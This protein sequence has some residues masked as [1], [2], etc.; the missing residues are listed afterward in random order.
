MGGLPRRAT[1]I[2]QE[3]DQ[4]LGVLILDSGNFVADK[5]LAE[6]SL[7]HAGLKAELILRA[8]DR[9]GYHAMAVGEMDLYLGLKRL[10]DLSSMTGVSLLSANLV[11]S[12]GKALFK[13]HIVLKAGGTTVG[14]IGLT[15]TPANRRMFSQRVPGVTVTDPN[16]AAKE[17]I[18]DIREECDLV[19]VLS[20]IGYLRDLELVKAVPGIDILISG[21]TKRFMRRP[22]IESG[23]L[24]TS[25][26][27]E[28][29]AVGKL[30]M[31][32]DGEIKGWISRQEL[33]LMDKQIKAAVKKVGTPAGKLRHDTLVEKR[34]E[35]RQWTKY[36]PDLINLDPSFADDPQVA[37]M[38][39][40]YRK[41]LAENSVNSPGPEAGI[42]EQERY[43]G[44]EVCAGC[45]DS[46]YRFWQTTDHFRAF[47]SLSPKSAVGDPD[48][49]PC[50]VTGYMRRTGYWP[51]APREDLRGVQCEACHGVGSLHAKSPDLYSLLHL[52][53]APQ[54]M[55]CHTQ[56]Q[57]DDFD[58]LRDRVLVCSEDNKQ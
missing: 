13:T 34:E 58:Y 39:T 5:P 41:K 32:L 4:G 29:R 33:N 57:D 48:C 23:A 42:G 56:D 30:V 45:H 14:V 46:R 31:E 55:D 28:G 37:S 10:T 19:V 35:A 20:N 25:G 49:L 7:E 17:E 36:K 53:A 26:Y 15:A 52:P 40:D 16:L 38:I 9:M 51:K 54:C 43:T 12:R 11:D 18:A 2:R 50:H 3:R 6:P 22:V 47:D 1:F 21:G 27:Y 44:S 24:V 8:M